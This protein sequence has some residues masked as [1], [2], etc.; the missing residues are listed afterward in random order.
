MEL[1][2]VVRGFRGDAGLLGS[3]PCEYTRECGQETSHLLQA[4]Y[5]LVNCHP[6]RGCIYRDQL[7]YLAVRMFP[8]S[9][10]RILSAPV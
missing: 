2:R 10:Y 4:S 5:A 9:V 3:A 8:P 6:P 1:T 7:P